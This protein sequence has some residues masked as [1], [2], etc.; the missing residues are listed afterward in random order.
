MKKFE[1]VMIGITGILSIVSL[2]RLAVSPIPPATD[3]LTMLLFISASIMLGTMALR[4]VTERKER[5]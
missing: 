5:K 2:F 3:G 4:E 1:Q